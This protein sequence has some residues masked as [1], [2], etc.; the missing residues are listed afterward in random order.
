M[1]DLP[2]AFAQIV[3]KMTIAR[4]LKRQTASHMRLQVLR[5][6]YAPLRAYDVNQPSPRPIWDQTGAVT[7]HAPHRMLQQHPS[8]SAGSKKKNVFAAPGN[9]QV[10]S[11][12]SCTE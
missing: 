1:L 2:K 11:C 10:P 12:G 9:D 3:D 5:F 6:Y 4:Y 8:I 7:P